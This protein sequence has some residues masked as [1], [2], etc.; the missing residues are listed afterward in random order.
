MT[1]YW[2][3]ASNAGAPLLVFQGGGYK[4]LAIDLEG[5]EVCDWLIARGITCVV[6]KYRVTDGGP[7]WEN[8]CNCEVKPRAPMALEDAQRAVGL[9]RFH[10]TEYHIDPRRIGVLGFSAGGHLVSDISTHFE[11]RAYT[12]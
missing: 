3:K 7:H 11:K 2:G 12:P 10:A 4:M 9:L 1:V 5:T 6:L 8:S